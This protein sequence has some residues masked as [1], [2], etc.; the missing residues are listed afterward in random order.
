MPIIISFTIDGLIKHTEIDVCLATVAYQV[1][2]INTGLVGPANVAC[3]DN[4][5]FLGMDLA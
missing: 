5:G 3:T 2:I 4:E 1:V